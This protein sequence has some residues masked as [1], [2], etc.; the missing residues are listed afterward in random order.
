MTW[1]SGTKALAARPTPQARVRV[2]PD[3]S[4][5]PTRGGCVMANG[6]DWNRLMRA[7][8][9]APSILNTRP[10]KFLNLPYD[11]IEL[12]ADWDQRLEFIDRLHRE[13]FISCG[14]ALLNIRMAIRVT[15][16]DP[17]IWLLTGDPTN[18][19]VACPHCNLPG[20]LALIEKG[21]RTRPT[22]LIE[23]RLYEAIPQRHTVR[24]PFRFHGIKMNMII[25][26]LQAAR[27]EGVRARLL[28]RRETRQLLRWTARVDEQLEQNPSYLAELS[29]WTGNGTP[30]GRGVSAATFGP[31]PRKH[32]HHPPV[33][34]LGLTWHGPR[35]VENFENY[36]QLI[37]LESM[38]DTPS[39]WIHIGQ[40]LQR[41]LLTA[42]SYHVQASFLTQQ[43]EEEDR[44][45]NSSLTGQSWPW[46]GSGQMII[47]VGYS[48][49][50]NA[51]PIPGTPHGSLLE[52]P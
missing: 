20:R 15:G 40:A 49:R 41:L 4:L 47:R 8:D 45:H 5:T 13:L 33:R 1:A 39:E 26:L 27:M 42:T 38:E 44:N 12:Q 23:H 50:S 29:H 16:D 35:Q 18:Y 19:A 21:Q 28:H 25:E 6:T 51:L 2:A 37:A 17:L 52:I 36:P 30:P 14:A 34:D 22:T 11:D 10:W 31:K 46:H 24:E 3:E 7:A 32:Q 43:F 48:Q 9:A